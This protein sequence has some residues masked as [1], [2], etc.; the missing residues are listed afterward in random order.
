MRIQQILSL[1]PSKH[2]K[3]VRDL[4]EKYLGSDMNVLAINCGG[5]IRCFKFKEEQFTGARELVERGERE[6]VRKLFVQSL[7]M[8]GKNSYGNVA[9][10]PT[11]IERDNKLYLAEA[12]VKAG[13]NSCFFFDSKDA[14]ATDSDGAVFIKSHGFQAIN[15]PNSIFQDSS[16]Y[17]LDSPSVQAYNSKD[18]DLIN[19]P[20]SKIRN[21]S[22]Q[23]EG[24]QLRIE[25]LRN[26]KV[27][28]G[29]IFPTSIFGR[30]RRRV[31]GKRYFLPGYQ[32]PQDT[33]SVQTAP[34]NNTQPSA[35]T[36]VE[37]RPRSA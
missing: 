12:I 3:H 23:K 8:F 20:G 29:E 36:P 27:E 7:R 13:S 10:F 32:I 37:Q 18:L 19:C 4:G 16:G 17:A 22:Y 2:R 26:K 14:S 21:T 31:T 33:K 35:I 28:E 6:L 11:S 5:R 9:F 24:E 25:D 15:C 34:P 1:I 30:I